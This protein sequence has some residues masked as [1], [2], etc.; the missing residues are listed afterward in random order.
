MYERYLSYW[1]SMEELYR[2]KGRTDKP[3]RTHPTPDDLVQLRTEA[4]FFVTQFRYLIIGKPSIGM[5]HLSARTYIPQMNSTHVLPT[6]R[7]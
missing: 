6:P 3:D 2:E 1:E 4:P 7:R 5:T